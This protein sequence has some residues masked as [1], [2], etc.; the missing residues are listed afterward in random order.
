MK[1]NN[2]AL[3][4]VEIVVVVV[5]ALLLAAMLIPAVQSIHE[6]SVVASY[7]AGVTLSRADEQIAKAAI[8]KGKYPIS[9][10]V[11]DGMSIAE[12]NGHKYYL[13]STKTS[14][15]KITV[16]GEVYYLIPIN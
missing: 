1:S 11:P 15:E 12:I 9:A 8:A 14:L 3:T 10:D 6:G 2:K 4:V 5:I 13:V 7:R 16:Q